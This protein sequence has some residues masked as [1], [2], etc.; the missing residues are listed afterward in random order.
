[1]LALVVATGALV[2]AP[3]ALGSRATA[4]EDPIPTPDGPAGTRTSKSLVVGIDGA[5]LAQIRSAD[6]PVLHA[7][8]RGGTTSLAYRYGTAPAG[9]T[10]E[11]A[12][13][14]GP[15][16]STLLSGVWPDK[17]GVRDNTFEG[18]RL[19]AWPDYLSRAEAIDPTLSTFAVADWDP[20]ATASAGG[21]IIGGGVDVRIG[22]R[23]DTDGRGYAVNDERSTDVAARYLES[24][25]PDLSFVYL[26]LV[27]SVGHEHGAA[28][29]EYAAALETVDAQIGRL[30]AAIRARPTSADEDWQIVVTNDHGHTA[31]GG[32]GGNTLAERQQFVI[33]QGG[34]IAAG[35]RRDDLN[36]TDIV[37]TA[38]AHV[39]ARRASGL[40]GLPVGTVRP[41]DFDRVRGSLRPR[42]D[43]TGIPSSRLG[44]TPT[45]PPGWRVD[46]SRMPQGGVRE[47]RGWT[48]ATDPF[49]TSAQTSQGRENFVRA[50]GVLAVADSDE[51][52]DA[53]H[54]PGRFDSTLVS[55]AYAV[56]PGAVELRFQ[57][58]YQQEG[59]QRGRVLVSFD[60]RAPRSVATYSSNVSGPQRLTIQVPQGA[61]SM[62]VR[63]R[64]TGDNDWYWALDD[65]RLS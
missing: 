17:H 39:G 19:G 45:A 53:D 52:D 16:W 24:R 32:H 14:S 9:L 40:D 48:F 7:L 15:G 5:G 54:G 57:T 20:I 36:V 38:Y 4:V 51:W 60:A 23:S 42:V 18:K 25:G 43:E 63:F 65:V 44:W 11:A 12:T 61:S 2:A 33:A 55:P 30:L 50:R 21:P 13:V 59:A 47:W 28:S 22:L 31:S 1:M 34:G 29:A 62:R 49:W 10:Q 37:P 35:V 41:D 8:M 6:T 58:H 56:E 46:N 26:G 27:D 64:Y 3:P